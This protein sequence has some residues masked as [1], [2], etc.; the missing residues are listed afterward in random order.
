[1]VTAT[2]RRIHFVMGTALNTKKGNIENLW[3]GVIVTHRLNQST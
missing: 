2:A 1:M 3:E